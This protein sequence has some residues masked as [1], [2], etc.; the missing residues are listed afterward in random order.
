M[1]ADAMMNGCMAGGAR[2]FWAVVHRDVIGSIRSP[3]GFVQDTTFNTGGLHTNGVDYSATYHASLDTFGISNMGS[4]SANLVGTWLDNLETTV[5][6]GGTPIDC[7]GLY[8]TPCHALGGSPNPNPKW[9]HKLR[10]TWNTPFE[11]G[12]FGGLGLSAQW[13][14]YSEV[15]LDATSSQPALA[16]TV[17]PTDAKFGARSYLDLLATFKVKD[18]Y[19]FRV[20]VN[21]VLDQDPPLT[22]ANNCPAGPCNQNVYAQMH[23]R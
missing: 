11:Y 19:S 10:V 16:G 22:G 18:N 20:G 21:N 3:T 4:M 2:S 13:R 5:L 1:G 15:K 17:F 9:R 23:D 12:W 8:G 14:F 7:A 6:N